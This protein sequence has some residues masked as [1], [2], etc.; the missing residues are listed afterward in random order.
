[1]QGVIELTNI[2]AARMESSMPAGYRLARRAGG[3]LVLQGCFMWSQGH[4]NGH[5]WRDIPTVSL[6]PTY[7]VQH[8]P[9]DST[10]GGET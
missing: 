6:D 8:L 4:A 2:A 7:T 3:E 9:S 10:E 1:M 5:E